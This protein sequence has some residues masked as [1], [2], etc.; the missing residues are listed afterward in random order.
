MTGDIRVGEQ[1]SVPPASAVVPSGQTNPI[2]DESITPLSSAGTHAGW[3]FPWA[4]ALDNRWAASYGSILRIAHASGRRRNALLFEVM[5]SLWS[6]KKI[7][8]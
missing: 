4:W 1:T 7:I 8:H 3:E 2:T 5:G 6:R